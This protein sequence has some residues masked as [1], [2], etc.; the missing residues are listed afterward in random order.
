MV[1]QIL[2][3]AEL[4]LTDPFESLSIT[5]DGNF[6]FTSKLEAGDAYEVKVKTQPAN[7]TCS[8][9]NG[10]GT[11]SDANIANFV[12]TC[13]SQYTLGGTVTGLTGTLKLRDFDAPIYQKYVDIAADGAFVFPGTR[14][15]GYDCQIDVIVQPSGQTFTLAN[16][17]GIVAGNVTNITV[18]C[19]TTPALTYSIGGTV[20]GI[21]PTEVVTLRLT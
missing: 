7:A 14:R 16:D 4:E 3:K 8:V 21:P 10:T 11:V 2:K 19:V 9:T 5:A 15:A 18:T 13:A 20:A 17:L 12:V 6:V 1:N